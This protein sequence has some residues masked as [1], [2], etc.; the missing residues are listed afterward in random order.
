[1]RAPLGDGAG[2]CYL[3]PEEIPMR[4]NTVKSIELGESIHEEFGSWEEARKAARLR[5]GVYVL[6]PRSKD[7]QAPERKP[8]AKA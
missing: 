7:E 1:M 5:D 6:P 2:R 8:S 4:V 3:W